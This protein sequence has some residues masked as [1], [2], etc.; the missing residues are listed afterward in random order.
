MN[1][2]KLLQ[3]FEAKGLDLKN[4]VVMAPLTRSRADSTSLAPTELHVKYYKQR[5][6][7]GL[8]I[9]EGIVINENATGYIDVPG[10]YTSKQIQGWKKVTDGVH[11]EEGKIFAQL[12]HVGRISHPDLLNGMLPLAPSAVNPNFQTFTKNGFTDIITPKAMLSEDIERTIDDFQKA[13]INAVSSGFDGVE[14]HSANGYLFHQFFA[15]CSN[16]R[17]DKYGGSIEN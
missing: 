13:T 17:T 15:K 6:T 8:I 11:Q 4:R 3:S 10:I 14:L 9:T 5:A 7:A 12:W 2:I 1:E 16:H